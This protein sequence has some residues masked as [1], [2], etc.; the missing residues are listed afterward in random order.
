MSHIF[1]SVRQAQQ[2]EAAQKKQMEAERALREEVEAKEAERQLKK[3]YKEKARAK[4]PPKQSRGRALPQV[5]EYSDDEEPAPTRRQ[6]RV[7]VPTPKPTKRLRRATTTPSLTDSWER[8]SGINQA[9]AHLPKE[10][11]GNYF[12][13][14]R[15]NAVRGYR[16]LLRGLVISKEYLTQ[17]E[18]KVLNKHKAHV[19]R[20]LKT[21][22]KD[23][24]REAWAAN[25][26]VTSTIVNLVNSLEMVDG[27]GGAPKG[28]RRGRKATL[29]PPTSMDDYYDYDDDYGDDDY[30]DDYGQQEDGDYSFDEA[31]DDYMDDE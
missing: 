4:A 26:K 28:D 22:D 12:Q 11:Y 13:G 23:K 5:E 29:S 6:R 3:Q 16:D 25:P 15:G 21:Q 31:D 17:D 18:K 2:A 9:V 7:A 8:V 14:L 10:T 30:G 19:T 24:L 27:A 20:L 1:A